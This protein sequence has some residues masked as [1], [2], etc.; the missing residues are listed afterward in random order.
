[1]IAS[2]PSPGTRRRIFLSLYSAVF[3]TMIGV[4]IVIPL[5]PRYAATLGA[6]GIWIGAIFSAFALSRALFLPVFGRLS[7]DHGR[8]RLIILGLCMYSLISF[9]YT[10]AG[11]VYEITALRFIHGIASAMVLP[12][13]IAY[14]SEIAPTGEEGRFVGSFAS[15]VSLGMSLGPFIGGV[16]SDIFTM[17][18]VFHAMTLL[19]L[20][21]LATVFFFLPELPSRPVQKSPIRAVMAYK[22]LRGPILYQLM[23]ALAN[24]TFMVFLPVAAIKSGGLSASET[25]LIILVSVLATPV[26]QYFFSRIADQFDRYYLIAGGTA[27]I[28]TSLLVLPEFTGLLPYLIAALL[29]GVG[30]AV[31]LP[32]MYA[33][34]TVAGREVGQGSASALVNTVLSIGLVISPLFSGIVMDISGTQ[35]VFYVAGIASICCTFI[36]F[37]MDQCS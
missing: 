8:R 4:G 6:T 26:F 11:S 5:F 30:R 24:G 13:A 18:A 29:M 3:A 19:S 37:R 33:V 31:S 21:A 2:L 28:G 17:D 1:M 12:V 10:L 36:F 15:S 20:A 34:V 14:I 32:A 35:V 9:L 25:G 27:M 16:I 7:D 22:P 23:Y